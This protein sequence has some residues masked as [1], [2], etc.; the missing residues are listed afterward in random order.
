MTDLK[1]LS[2]DELRAAR[3]DLAAALIKEGEA[4]GLNQGKEEAKAEA[5]SVAQAAKEAEN[6]RIA[7]IVK[8]GSDIPGASVIALECIK[9][10]MDAKSAELKMKDA[11]LADLQKNAPAPMGAGNTAENLDPKD[12]LAK[13]KEYQKEHKCSIEQALSKTAPKRS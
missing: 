1:T 12:H 13:A 5:Q 2:L 9:D 11:R 4:K 10:G 7:A 6:A 8:I 3:P